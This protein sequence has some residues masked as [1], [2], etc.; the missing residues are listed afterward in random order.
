MP[1]R[2]G[3]AAQICRKW[4]NRPAALLGRP[5]WH[6]SALGGSQGQS[7][8]PQ[9]QR[10]AADEQKPG[11]EPPGH[12]GRRSQNEGDGSAECKEQQGQEAGETHSPSLPKRQRYR[13][14]VQVDDTEPPPA[15]YFVALISS[16][17]VRP[18]PQRARKSRSLASLAE[19][20][21]E[22]SQ[23]T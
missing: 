17:G 12:Q 3:R 23:M 11:P 19:V 10:W 7:Q 5:G 2:R 1:R 21:S 4:K 18:D 8:G 22:I 16:L 14:S 15:R 9:G 20:L 13:L 6:E